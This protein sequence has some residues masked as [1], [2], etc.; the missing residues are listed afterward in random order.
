MPSAIALDTTRVYWTNETVM[1]TVMSV[2]LDG[3]TPVTLASAQPLPSSIAVGATG[4]YWFNQGSGQAGTI[5][6]VPIDGGSPI[7]LAS[8]YFPSSAI[9]IDATYIYYWDYLSGTSTTTLMKL[10][11]SGGTAS[12]LASAPGNGPI[13]VNGTSVYWTFEPAGGTVDEGLIL[14]LNLQN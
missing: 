10:P 3:G 12:P 7:Q 14:K 6:T 11:L 8:T 9:A 1:G 13:V 5:M 4:V 2:P